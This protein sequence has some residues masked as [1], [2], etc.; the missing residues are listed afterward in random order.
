MKSKILMI[1]IYSCFTMMSCKK[2]AESTKTAI[3]DAPQVDCY[4]A[5]FEKDTVN[6]KINTFKDGTVTGNMTMKQFET[7]TK[8]G[9]INGGYHGDT[10]MVDYNYKSGTTD[11][12]NYEN[13]LALLKRGNELIMGNGKI[14]TYL[15]KTFFVKNAPIDYE[16]IRFKFTKL[17]CVK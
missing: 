15:G 17:D 5:I 1:T 2:E 9:E 16:N 13:P 12:T 6:L 3:A 4:Q 8:E 14:E 11:K 10:L 7:P